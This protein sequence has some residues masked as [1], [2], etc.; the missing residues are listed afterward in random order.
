MEITK[1]KL[2][3]EMNSMDMQRRAKFDFRNLNSL[4]TEF[5]LSWHSIEYNIRPG[6][7]KTKKMAKLPR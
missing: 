5:V 6:R 1:T 3:K 7:K 4:T 2:P